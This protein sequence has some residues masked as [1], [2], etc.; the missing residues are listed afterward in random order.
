MNCLLA[1][2]IFL[3][4]MS[5]LSSLSVTVL[6]V[7]DSKNVS[8]CRS[9]HRLVWWLIIWCCACAIFGGDFWLNRT[10]EPQKKYEYR[11]LTICP[12]TF[13]FLGRKSQHRLFRWLVNW[14]CSCVVLHSHFWLRIALE[15]DWQ[16][17][18][19]AYIQDKCLH[20]SRLVADIPWHVQV[21]N[22]QNL[23]N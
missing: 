17:K 3:S 9:Q 12:P 8:V 22:V 4:P 23:F 20:P 15:P 7:H 5:Q 1:S 2:Q 6:H 16:I 21:Q 14:C 19:H 10:F 18:V 13:G 11:Q